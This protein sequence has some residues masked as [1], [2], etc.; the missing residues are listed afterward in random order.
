MNGTVS[1][2]QM[3]GLRL[4]AVLIA[5]GIALTACG[6]SSSGGTSAASTTSPTSSTTPSAAPTSSLG[7][8]GS[9]SFCLEAKAEE[10]QASKEI[11]AFESDTP[12]QL[13]AFAQHVLAELQTFTSSA[14]S[15]IKADV[16]IAVAADQKIFAAL[17]KANYNYKNVSPTAF[18]SV[19]TPAFKRATAAITKYF[20]T[21][22]G[23]SPSSVPT[24]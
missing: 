12:A 8:L 14:P 13:S 16:A 11:K 22:C 5:A 10:A 2:M 3:R 9:G 24:G 20:Q 17:K 15:A 6:S 1:T 7:A 4:S 21:K 18:E 19:D 23:I